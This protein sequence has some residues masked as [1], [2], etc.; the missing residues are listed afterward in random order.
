MLGKK[1]QPFFSVPFNFSHSLPVLLTDIHMM[2]SVAPRVII[3]VYP[4]APGLPP[5]FQSLPPKTSPSMFP[6]GSSEMGCH[7]T[8]MGLGSELGLEKV[9]RFTWASKLFLFF[10]LLWY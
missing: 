7:G 3:N 4:Y 5:P 9:L 2:C 10:A 6:F 8:E 1:F